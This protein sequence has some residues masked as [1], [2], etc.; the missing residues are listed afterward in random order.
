MLDDA[1]GVRGIHVPETV[2]TLPTAYSKVDVILKTDSLCKDGSLD[3]L[4]LT[5]NDGKLLDA[6]QIIGKRWNEN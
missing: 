4:F 2:M 3:G 6:Y 1:G 5:A